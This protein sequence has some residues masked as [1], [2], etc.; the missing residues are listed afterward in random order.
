MEGQA[1]PTRKSEVKICLRREI[2]GLK[3]Y[4]VLK[5]VLHNPCDHQRTGRT[6]ASFP[7]GA[8][9]P[10]LTHIPARAPD[11]LPHGAGGAGDLCLHAPAPHRSG[12]DSPQT[13]F[14]SPNADTLHFFKTRWL[15][16]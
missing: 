11:K 2:F 5:S 9:E 12:E 15:G 14:L 4:L 16:V 13:P 7:P 6:A 8:G 10:L 3:C 1:A